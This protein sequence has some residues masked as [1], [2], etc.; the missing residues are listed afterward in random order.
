MKDPSIGGALVSPNAGGT[1]NWEPPAYSPDTGLFYVSERNSF[2]IFYLMDPDPRGSMGLGGIEQAPVGSA[3][4]FLTAI[5]PT[6]G[7]I[8]WRRPYPGG[9]TGGGGGLL[10]T[11]GGLVFIGATNDS[12]FRAFDAATGAL[13]WETMLDASAHATPMT[14]VG[15]DGRQYVV[16][17]AGGHKYL[18]T[19]LGD[20]VVAFALPE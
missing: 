15:K 6:T 4:S 8:A 10:T 3:G 14:F 13:L 20:A 2:S 7:K 16:I 19:A 17:A 1:I 11:A 5:D 9:G 18:G 12:R